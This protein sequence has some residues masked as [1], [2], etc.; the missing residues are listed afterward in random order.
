S[1]INNDPEFFKRCKLVCMGWPMDANDLFQEMIIQMNDK[2]LDLLNDLYDRGKLINYFARAC[3]WQVKSR[4]S[5][6]YF[7]YIKNEKNKS[8]DGNHMDVDRELTAAEYVRRY[9]ADRIADDDYK[10]PYRQIHTEGIMYEE[11]LLDIAEKCRDRVY[12]RLTDYQIKV[13]NKYQETLST[14]DTA[15]KL[16]IFQPAVTRCVNP[17]KEMIK[18][19]IDKYLSEDH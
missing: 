15:N 19:E 13:F 9:Y 1:H 18:D 8:F 7:K 11:D 2:D 4:N 12:K 3:K 6:V 14:V 5:Y 17:I 10:E 16:Y